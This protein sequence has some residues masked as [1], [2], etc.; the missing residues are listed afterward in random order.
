[1]KRIVF[2]IVIV[3]MI[4]ICG[5]CETCNTKSVDTGVVTAKAMFPIANSANHYYTITLN[6]STYEVSYDT[7]YSTR[8]GDNVTL[9]LTCYCY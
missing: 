3:A 8:V 5:C 6:N 9:T 2:A 7:F 1:M 4:L